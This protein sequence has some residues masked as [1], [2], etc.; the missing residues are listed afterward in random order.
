T[1]RRTAKPRVQTE[2]GAIDTSELLGTVRASTE[3]SGLE[4]SNDLVFG[5]EDR[6]VRV[7][8]RRR[9]QFAQV[10]R[11][12]A[13]HEP[14]AGLSRVVEST[15]DLAEAVAVHRSHLAEIDDDV[16]ATLVDQLFNRAQQ[17]ARAVGECHPPGGH[18]EDDDAINGAFDD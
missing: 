9:E 8:L 13:Q 2:L 5:V 14:A 7:E 1:K 16:D 15:H 11:D 3:R 6:D 10:R 17:A 12:A 4:T 18:I